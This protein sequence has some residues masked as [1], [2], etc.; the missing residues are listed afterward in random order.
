[1]SWLVP[2]DVHH[3]ASR[4]WL[5]QSFA[6]AAFA[7]IVP[8]LVFPE[9]AGA[10][11]RRSG[12]SAGGERAQQI[13]LRLPRLQTVALDPSLAEE[14]GRLAARL[15]LRGADAVY[16]AT[17]HR[18]GLGLVTWDDELRTRS[19]GLIPARRP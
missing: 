14:A 7:P 12:L 15:G 9:V 1:M 3:A 13:L 18:L 19:G 10:V 11:A 16:V 2:G 17:A 4:R 8:T 6:D 5:R